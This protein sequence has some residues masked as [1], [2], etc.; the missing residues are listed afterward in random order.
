MPNLVP[1]FSED[2]VRSGDEIIKV[3]AMPQA[4]ARFGQ[5]VWTLRSQSILGKFANCAHFVQASV[6]STSLGRMFCMQN[7]AFRFGWSR[8]ARKKV[9]SAMGINCLLPF[10]KNHLKSVNIKDFEGK[11]IA[12]DASC[13]L[14]KALSISM[15][16]TGSFARWGTNV[17][18][19][20]SS[21]SYFAL[22]VVH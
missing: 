14:H 3:Y 6:E 19:L 4:S 11:I 21:P 20:N 5:V 15:L 9:Y 10:V 17:L 1:H 18:Y 22:S 8:I 7:Y 16:R 2:R 13:W 12:V